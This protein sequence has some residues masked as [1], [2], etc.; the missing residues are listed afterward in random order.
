MSELKTQVIHTFIS[1][2]TAQSID[3]VKSAI[4]NSQTTVKNRKGYKRTTFRDCSIQNMTNLSKSL[5]K[6]NWAE[7]LAESEVNRKY[8][9]FSKTLL[10]YFNLHCPLLSKPNIPQKNNRFKSNWMTDEIKHI[11]ALLTFAVG[12]VNSGEK[13]DKSLINKVKNNYDCK[14]VEAKREFYS[15]A[16]ENSSNKSKASWKIINQFR[17]KMSNAPLQRIKLQ[18]SDKYIFEE[19]EVAS[20]FNKFFVSVGEETVKPLANTVSNETFPADRVP[21]SMFLLPTNRKEISNIIHSLKPKHSVGYDQ[22]PIIIIKQCCDPIVEV[23]VDIINCMLDQGV[24]PDSLKIAKVIPIFK[25]GRRTDMNNYRP[26]SILP[27][28]SKVFERVIYVRVAA[29]LERYNLVTPCQNGF[30]KGK[31]TVGALIGIVEAI[32]DDIDVGKFSVGVMLDLTKAFDCVNINILLEKLHNLGIRGVGQD[33]LR[34]YLSARYQFVAVGGE[35]DA[36]ASSLLQVKSGVPQGSILGPLLFILYVND[37]QSALPEIKKLTLYADDT[38]LLFSDSNMERLEVDSNVGCNSVV[39]YFNEISLNINPS[40][41]EMI[42]FSLRPVYIEP[43]VYVDDSHIANVVS[44]SLLGLRLDS[45]LLWNDHVDKIVSDLS[46]GLF[47]LRFIV[48]YVPATTART[49]YF[50]LMYSHI[51]YGIELWGSTADTH[52]QKIFKLQKQAVRYLAK[53]GYNDSCRQSFKNLS[54]LTLPCIYIYRLLIYIYTNRYNFKTNSDIHPYNTRTKTHIVV[55]RHRLHKFEKKPSYIGSRL[56]NKLPKL[57]KTSESLKR[58][59]TK[60]YKFLAEKAYYGVDE[61]LEE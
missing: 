23:L 10:H 41:C 16:I 51:T 39:Q 59:K 38:T 46:K 24:F 28:L 1:D 2:H 32:I 45:K 6:N 21:Y 31:S 36:A 26:I 29:Y 44:V 9:L 50:S 19:A 57:I 18:N 4:K 53:L 5:T 35:S 55:E 48:K 43:K 11:K 15:K 47:V 8:D 7:V 56:Y 22:I 20:E 12:K 33:L 42:D 30:V 14:V 54:L 60:L 52:F 34:S 3:F 13:I 49:V 27:A 40:K 61:Y 58:F 37:I 17:G 25:K